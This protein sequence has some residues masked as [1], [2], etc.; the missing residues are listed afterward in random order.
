MNYNCTFGEQYAQHQIVIRSSLMCS[1]INYIST[2]HCMY[3]TSLD[4]YNC[5]PCK[6]LFLTPFLAFI[7]N[8]IRLAASKIIPQTRSPLLDFPNDGTF[9]QI[10]HHHHHHH[11]LIR[12]KRVGTKR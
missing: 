3:R 9:Q 10:Y 2:R 12:I 8:L 6:A 7:S 11:R 4:G 1:C 5:I